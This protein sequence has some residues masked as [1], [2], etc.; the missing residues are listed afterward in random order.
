VTGIA[1]LETA[2]NNQP[3]AFVSLLSPSPSPALI[4]LIFIPIITENSGFDDASF[5]QHAF[6]SELQVADFLEKSWRMNFLCKDISFPEEQSS[7]Q[8]DSYQANNN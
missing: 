8:I 1:K 7:V 2:C 4:D 6:I 3:V 5:I